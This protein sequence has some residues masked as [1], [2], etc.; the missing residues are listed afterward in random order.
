MISKGFRRFLLLTL[1]CIVLPVIVFLI[2]MW[3]FP[4]DPA[5]Y[6]FNALLEADRNFMSSESDQAAAL[7]WEAVLEHR[8]ALVDLGALHEV[9]L[10]LRQIN[11]SSDEFNE[12][13]DILRRNTTEGPF[14]QFEWE[15]GNNSVPIGIRIWYKPAELSRWESDFSAYGPRP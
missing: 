10:P 6:H 11:V 14:A 4:A 13:T 9:V 8:Q 5:H 7:H 1:V 2:V 3:R 12:L 15:E